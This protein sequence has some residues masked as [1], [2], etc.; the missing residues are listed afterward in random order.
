MTQSKTFEEQIE[1][2]FREVE[3]ELLFHELRPDIQKYLINENLCPKSNID[4]IIDSTYDKWK[5]Y[6]G[7]KLDLDKKIIFDPIMYEKTI[8]YLTCVLQI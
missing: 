7:Y 6:E 8:S 3:L 1:S 5:L 4:A 2:I